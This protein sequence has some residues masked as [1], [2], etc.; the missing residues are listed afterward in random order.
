M[1]ESE[2]ALS[3]SDA[4][5]SL[6]ALNVPNISINPT[7]D[8]VLSEVSIWIDGIK[9]LNA[10]VGVKE[11]DYAGKKIADVVNDVAIPNLKVLF[12]YQNIMNALKHTCHIYMSDT[13]DSSIPER[14]ALDNACTSFIDEYAPSNSL[15]QICTN[16]YYNDAGTIKT[17]GAANFNYAGYPGF[18]AII[19]ESLNGMKNV[20]T[21]ET[22]SV[23]YASAI[24]SPA[25]WQNFV[26]NADFF[27]DVAN[28]DLTWITFV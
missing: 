7:Q 21:G 10:K 3:R 19:C 22:I 24:A 9:K 6:V 11:S 8:D 17:V 13:P 25:A 2:Q 4:N 1:V 12:G 26:D 18:M 5:Q 27:D 23:N 14:Q 28:S 16:L 15:R 20:V